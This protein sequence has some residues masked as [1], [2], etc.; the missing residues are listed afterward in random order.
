MSTSQ[1]EQAGA[2]DRHV[3][4]QARAQLLADLEHEFRLSGHPVWLGPADGQHER[5]LRV[6]GRACRPDS[7]S[8]AGRAAD[9]AADSA[10]HRPRQRSHLGTPGHGA[11]RISSL[12]RFSVR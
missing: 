4:P 3:L 1:T 8:V 7:D 10:A 6:P 11:G 12:A 2:K 5:H 9:R